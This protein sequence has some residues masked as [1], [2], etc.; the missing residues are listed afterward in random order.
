[1]VQAE[2]LGWAGLGVAAEVIPAL[3]E[4]WVW[5]ERIPTPGFS[6][7]SWDLR[8]AKWAKS[9][10]RGPFSSTQCGLT[11]RKGAAPSGTN[12]MF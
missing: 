1:M 6:S 9:L 3:T 10:S 5:E 2:G 11:A 4:G 12:Q 7:C 8:A